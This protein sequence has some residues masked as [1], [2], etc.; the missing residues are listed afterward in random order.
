MYGEITYEEIESGKLQGSIVFVDVRTSSEFMEATIP[1]A[2]N[3]PIMDEKE[4]HEIGTVFVNDD[5]WKAKRMGII[6][7]SKKLP[8][9][10]V[11]IEELYSRYDNVVL[12]CARGGYRSKVLF[13]IMRSMGFSIYKLKGGYKEYRGYI[14]NNLPRL[15]EDARFLVL[16]GKTGC[17]KTKI[18]HELEKIGVDTL[19]LERYANHRGSLLGDIG[20]GK[21]NSQKMF[22]SLI[23]HKLKEGEGRIF[24]VEG[25]SKRIGRII[26]QGYIYNKISGSKTVLIESPLDY[27]VNT[28]MDDYVDNNNEELMNHVG[29]LSGYISKE[30]I[31]NLKEKI[32]RNEYTYVIEELMKNY[33]DINYRLPKKYE[34][35]VY[36]DDE[37]KA[38]KEILD[39]VVKL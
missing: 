37:K 38:A 11:K 22:E 39:I 17:G 9:I 32:K 36:N 18:L 8:D 27:R 29:L 34:Y 2:V 31:E 1:N 7:G 6:S 10:Y 28:I 35:K 24:V 30:R 25:E 19:D 16:S 14:N 33:Y 26:M 12:F 23:Y 21:Q 13:Y 4:R 5:R 3:I 15:I 20:L